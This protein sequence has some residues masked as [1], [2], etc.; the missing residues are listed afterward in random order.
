MSPTTSEQAFHD[1]LRARRE[2]RG[3]TQDEL[4][5]ALSVTRA[6]ISQWE[7]GRHRPSAA[8]TRALDSWLEADGALVALAENEPGRSSVAE[9]DVPTTTLRELLSQVAAALDR[10]LVRNDEGQPLGWRHNLSSEEEHRPVSTAFGVKATI[11][12]DELAAR[13]LAPL[14]DRLRAMALPGGG[15]PTSNQ[16]APS[17]EASSVVVD[18]LA[19]L[20]PAVDVQPHLEMLE[21][22]VLEDKVGLRHPAVLTSVLETLL[23][24]CPNADLTAK[25]LRRLLGT[26]REWMV[27]GKERL[28][29]L[30][31]DEKRLASPKPSTPH[32]ARAVCVLARARSI[33]AVAEMTTEVDDAIDVTVEWLRDSRVNYHMAT[34]IVQRGRGSGFFYL[35]HF[36][37]AWVA[38]ALLL[39]GNSPSD[40]GVERALA[41]VWANYDPE[42][43]LWAWP[44]GDLPIWMTFDG[45]A[46]AHLAASA[47]YDVRLPDRSRLATT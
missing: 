24:L 5:E 23:D 9:D 34:E 45:I 39:A 37:S 22:I 16:T 38:R 31:K 25:L 21:R 11:A 17:P 6:T 2:R 18:A 40:G 28:L 7:T 36:T 12:L 47:L 13:R 29:W 32:S 43:G 10:H 41:D 8:R 19:R 35:R 46:A 20:D 1:A 3:L 15:W 14:A 33:D 44:N 4:A 42:H 30:E 26:R 27:R